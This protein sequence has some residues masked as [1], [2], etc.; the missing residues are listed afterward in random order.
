MF[1]TNK[2]KM[3]SS[4]SFWSKLEKERAEGISMGLQRLSYIQEANT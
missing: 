4:G 3:Y 1:T 2:K